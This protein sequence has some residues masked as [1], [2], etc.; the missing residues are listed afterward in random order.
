MIKY[1]SQDPISLNL[2]CNLYNNPFFLNSRG[3]KYLKYLLV[4][5]ALAIIS[6]RH[7]EYLWLS[8][9][10]KILLTTSSGPSEL[11]LWPQNGYFW[12]C[13]SRATCGLPSRLLVGVYC[14][15][16]HP[17]NPSDF[18]PPQNTGEKVS[19][20]WVIRSPSSRRIRLTFT[21]FVLKTLCCSCRQDFLEI[22]DGA[23]ESAP[24]IGRFCAKRFPKIVYSTRESIWIR[25][26]SD[27]RT[28]INNRFRLSF[29]DICGRHMASWT[30]SFTSPNFPA[31]YGLTI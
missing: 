18:Q 4:A 6:R 9:S 15:Q 21:D 3:V 22:R 1:N 14:G 12:L 7:T 31:K 27:F 16:I 20:D 24:L 13:F 19:C 5:I 28:D 30:G 2:I 25:F 8:F 29:E 26:E 23:N 10:R 11:C 17:L